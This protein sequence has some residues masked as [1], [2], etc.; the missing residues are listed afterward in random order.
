MQMNTGNHREEFFIG[1]S[2]LALAIAGVT[3]G[4]MASSASAAY[5]KIYNANSMATAPD[6]TTADGGSWTLGGTSPA[7]VAKGPGSEGGS[8]YWEVND[9]NTNSSTGATSSNSV[10][11]AATGAAADGGIGSALRDSAGWNVQFTLKVLNSANPTLTPPAYNVPT[12]IDVRNGR[13]IY[14]LAFVNDGTNEGVYHVAG[15]TTFNA[16]S[17]TLVK[18]LDLDVYHTFNMIYVP[19]VGDP[20]Q[21][22]VNVYIDGDYT[23]PAFTFNDSNSNASGTYR[24]LWGSALTAATQDVRWQNFSFTSPAPE[25]ATIGLAGVAGTMALLRRRRA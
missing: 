17:T 9:N 15:G 5:T 22:V 13:K 3:A 23:A 24:V 12:V 11:Y 4:A 21:D 25:P 1:R 2:L 6:P 14:D 20:T 10:S 18:A 19:N 16:D 7:T 8:N